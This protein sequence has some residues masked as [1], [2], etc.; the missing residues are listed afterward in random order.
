MSPDFCIFNGSSVSLSPLF[1][2]LLTSNQL[3]FGKSIYF[4][5]VSGSMLLALTKTRTSAPDI[6]PT[7]EEVT[8]DIAVVTNAPG[9]QNKAELT[10]RQIESDQPTWKTD[11]FDYISNILMGI[12][13]FS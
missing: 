4:L 13:C 9:V 7:L 3:D 6:Y 2:T 11:L 12:P 1:I 10:F 5:Q 8:K